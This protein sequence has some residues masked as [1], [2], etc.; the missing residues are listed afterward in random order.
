MI[1][2][3][4]NKLSSEKIKLKELKREIVLLKRPNKNVWKQWVSLSRWKVQSS[5][6]FL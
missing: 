4:E 3:H 5:G 6:L 1:P 2:S